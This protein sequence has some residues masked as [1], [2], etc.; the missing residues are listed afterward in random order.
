MAPCKSRR[1]AAAARAF[2]AHPPRAGRQVGGRRDV[3]WI[4]YE[5]HDLTLTQDLLRPP[6]PRRVDER[7]DVALRRRL[8]HAMTEIEHVHARPAGP[9]DACFDSFFYFLGGTQ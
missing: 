9:L 4:H 2:F 5:S 8:E 3:E 1:V 7:L 6:L